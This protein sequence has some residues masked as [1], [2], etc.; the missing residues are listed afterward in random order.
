MGRRRLETVHPFPEFILQR[1]HFLRE[2]LGIFNRL[3]DFILQTAQKTLAFL[4][5]ILVQEFFETLTEQLVLFH[6]TLHACKH[7]V[8]FHA[9]CPQQ[10]GEGLHVIP[11]GG[12]L[13]EINA[14]VFGPQ[15]L[16]LLL[17]LHELSA[18]C[19]GGFSCNREALV[20]LLT[21]HMQFH[22][23]PHCHP[24]ISFHPLGSSTLRAPLSH[25]VY[26]YVCMHPVM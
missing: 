26:A 21:W 12:N 25:N 24:S 9:L 15:S 14:A 2:E 13:M 5:I 19:L 8:I 3:E 23:T 17:R 1:L 16:A 18:G 4:L 11:Q 22:R 7:A 6:G 20:R 10:L